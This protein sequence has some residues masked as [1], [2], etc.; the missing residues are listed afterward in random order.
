MDYAPLLLFRLRDGGHPRSTGGGGGDLGGDEVD[1]E[2]PVGP[3]GGLD[4]VLGGAGL[5]LDAEGVAAGQSDDVA[6]LVGRPGITEGRG[7]VS[8][9]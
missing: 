6:L 3:L 8:L 1:V 9:R 2:L 7:W 4:A 5:E